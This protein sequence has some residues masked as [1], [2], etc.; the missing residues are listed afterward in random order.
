[1][2]QG[3]KIK[4]RGLRGVLGGIEGGRKITRPARG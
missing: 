3:A 1:L 4:R 2:R